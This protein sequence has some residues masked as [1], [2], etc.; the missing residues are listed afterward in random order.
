MPAY[1]CPPAASRWRRPEPPG[2]GETTVNSSVHL[3][4][5]DNVDL[6][7]HAIRAGAERVASHI[8]TRGQPFTGVSPQRLGPGGVDDRLGR[9]ARRSGGR[10]LRTGTCLPAGRGLLPPPSLPGPPQ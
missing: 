4:N 5:R 3:L 2:P 9:A 7:R 8:A 1:T 6:Y 10:A